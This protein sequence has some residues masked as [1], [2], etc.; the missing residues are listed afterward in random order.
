LEVEE[1]RKEQ[2]WENMDGNN[3]LPM[4]RKEIP[5]GPLSWGSPSILPLFPSSFS[6]PLN[7]GHSW[8]PFICLCPKVIDGKSETKASEK[9]TAVAVN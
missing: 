4:N 9:I 3:N 5:L 1:D 8:S 6:H 2:T 7:N